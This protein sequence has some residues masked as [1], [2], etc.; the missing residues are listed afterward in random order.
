MEAQL[1]P[2]LFV[3]HGAPTVALEPGGDYA[4]A[5]RAF[6]ARV[7]P[8]AVVVVS[9]HWQEAGPVRVG[10]AALPSTVHDFSGFAPELHAIQYPA[11]GAPELAARILATLEEDGIP[12]RA[13]PRRG[14]DHGAWIPLR[15]MWPEADVPVVPVSL[16]IPRLPEDLL[17]LG[18]ALS[19]LRREG[20]LLLGSGGIVHN[21][22]QVRLRERGAAA[23]E[24]ARTFDGWV[25]HRVDDLEIA[26]LISYAEKAK[27]AQRAVP[28][29][30]HFDPLF[31]VLGAALPGERVQ[32]VFE[33]FE[34]GSLSMRCFAIAPRPV[35]EEPRPVYTG[36][37]APAY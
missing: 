33:G 20:V 15:L 36:E 12:A 17:D 8:R 26:D 11:P 3:S 1:E 6:A 21:L 5:L 34:Y 14:L 32:Q 22:R 25:R 24:W 19:P 2:I 7:E 18:R 29:S 37:G 23:P 27:G 10:T 4:R 35:V 31:V 9:A 16:P 30:E 13:D 28:T